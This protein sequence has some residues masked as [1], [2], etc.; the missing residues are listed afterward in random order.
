MCF[1][2]FCVPG[3]PG[4]AHQPRPKRP[5][6]EFED[7]AHTALRIDQGR[8]EVARSGQRVVR[9]LLGGFIVDISGPKGE[10]WVEIRVP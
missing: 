5:K 10:I 3:R 4:R 2:Y 6:I 1:L 8:R 9:A 7:T